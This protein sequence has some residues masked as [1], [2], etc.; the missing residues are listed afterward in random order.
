M[1]P[2]EKT[3]VIIN[4]GTPFSPEV[5]VSANIRTLTSV[6]ASNLVIKTGVAL[7]VNH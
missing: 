4:S 5:N 1:H 2:N 7:L 6:P 3:N